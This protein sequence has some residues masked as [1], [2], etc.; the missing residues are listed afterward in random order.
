MTKLELVKGL[1]EKTGL[2]RKEV[3]ERLSFIDKA[4]EFSTKV[5]GVKVK[6]SKYFTVERKHIEAK[7]GEM[8]RVNENGVK[9]KVPYS[10]EAHD[11]LFF[12]KTTASKRV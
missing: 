6:L 4:V 12:K 2:T 9:V 8:T 11:E 3:E 1:S 5:P 10:T 7:T